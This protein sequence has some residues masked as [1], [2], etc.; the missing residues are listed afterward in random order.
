MKNLKNLMAGFILVFTLM[1]GAGTA[2]AG[3]LLSDLRGNN[4]QPCT[5]TG[6]NTD[7][8]DNGIL[9]TFTGIL[10]TFTGI[11]VTIADD[12]NTNCGVIVTDN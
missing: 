10:V 3:I 1:I 4:P 11:L 8:V 7:K 6:K 2:N 9:V 5:E 12:T